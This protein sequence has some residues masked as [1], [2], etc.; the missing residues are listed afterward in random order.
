MQSSDEIA[1][2]RAAD[3][4]RQS[5]RI[6]V[7]SG[8]GISTESGIPDFRSPGGIWSQYKPVEYS[9]FLSS[10]EAKERYWTRSR[11]TYRMLAGAL[12]NDAHQ[13]I[14]QLE[15]MGKLDCVITQ[16]VD[17]LHQK[18]GTTP[19]KVIELHGSAHWVECIRCDHR[20]PRG[21]WQAVLEA[22]AK[23]LDCP[24]CGGPLK[25]LTV[26]FGQP[27]PEWETMEAERRSRQCDLFIAVG[28][29]LVVYPAAQMPVYALNGGARV[30]VINMTQTYVDEVADIVIRQK[31]GYALPHIV[32]RL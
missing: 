19:E 14:V 2:R 15:Q 32:A 17:G 12:P 20:S 24:E 1:I 21:E 3:L 9:E 8:A 4:V 27:M 10:Q 7:F 13:A 23:V 6:V 22:G 29:S 25:A 31:A 5:S 18:A 16:N 28:S 26:S 30:V 11:E